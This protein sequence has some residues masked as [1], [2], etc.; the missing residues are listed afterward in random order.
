[1]REMFENA[2]DDKSGFLTKQEQVR[3]NTSFFCEACLCGHV[4]VLV[5]VLLV[6]VPCALVR[7]LCKCACCVHVV[8]VCACCTTRTRDMCMYRSVSTC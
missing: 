2:D 4:L 1:M 5:N 6:C 7:V 8:C 3:W